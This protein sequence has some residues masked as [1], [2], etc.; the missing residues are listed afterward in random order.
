MTETGHALFAAAERMETEIPGVVE[1]A[2]GPDD[3]AGTLRIC[4]PDGFGVAFLAPR[5]ADLRA[6]FPAPRIQL[7]PVPRN[8]SLSEREV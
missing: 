5:L 8:F 4:A 1:S 7:V 2:R 3:L 6:E